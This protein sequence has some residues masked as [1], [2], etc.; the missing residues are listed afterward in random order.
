[1]FKALG[2]VPSTE[3][4]KRETKRHRERRQTET[5]RQTGGE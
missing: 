2:L 5:K 4:E 1:M 3:R